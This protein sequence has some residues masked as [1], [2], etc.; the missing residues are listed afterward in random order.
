MRLR[1][2]LRASHCTLALL[3]AQIT[4]SPRKVLKGAQPM[5]A[6]IAHHNC[7]V[8][9][10]GLPAQDHLPGPSSCSWSHGPGLPG[11]IKTPGRHLP[12]FILLTSTFIFFTCTFKPERHPR[13]CPAS[14]SSHTVEACL[15]HVSRW[16]KKLKH[17]LSPAFHTTALAPGSYS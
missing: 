16:H 13:L 2:W 3:L 5:H 1:A 15:H 8:R 4:R 11:I 7:S 9:I 6:M 17:E 10:S 12:T 14:A